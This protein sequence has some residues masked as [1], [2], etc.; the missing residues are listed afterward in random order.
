MSKNIVPKLPFHSRGVTETPI[1]SSPVDRDRIAGSVFHRSRHP[2]QGVT[3]CWRPGSRSRLCVGAGSN[4]A[5][6]SGLLVQFFVLFG[7]GL[8]IS[9]ARWVA[10]AARFHLCFLFPACSARDCPG[11]ISPKLPARLLF[12]SALISLQALEAVQSRIGLF[13]NRDLQRDLIWA[14]L[15]GRFRYSFYPCFGGTRPFA[16]IK[17]PCRGAVMF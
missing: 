2:S 10:S 13:D 15:P 11:A 9:A 4:G 8:G 3:H 1:A 12:R 7:T 14:P 5:D 17:D 16:A 6:A